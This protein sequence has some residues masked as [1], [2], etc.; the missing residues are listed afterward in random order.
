MFVCCLCLV[1]GAVVVLA[2]SMKIKDIIDEN[3]KIRD[4]ELTVVGE[5]TAITHRETMGLFVVN[6]N[7]PNSS[8]QKK[9]T[10][11][12]IY[13]VSDDTASV[14][15]LS[16]KNYA[17]KDKVEFKAYVFMNSKDKIK[18]KQVELY[19]KYISAKFGLSSPGYSKFMLENLLT[20]AELGKDWVL[21]I[22]IGE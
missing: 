3:A 17:E 14:Y 13:L 2:D 10:E 8:D 22:D 11:T 20:N 6:M 16:T 19:D 21:L 18:D 4:Q 5:I 1:L 7:S 9:A 12:S 15:V